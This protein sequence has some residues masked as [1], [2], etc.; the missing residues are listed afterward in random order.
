MK[1]THRLESLRYACGLAVMMGLPLAAGAAE[2]SSEDVPALEPPKGLILAGF[3]ER[4]GIWMV[5]AALL[6][7][8]GIGGLIWWLRRRL[9]PVLP[10]PELTARTELKR[11]VS[12]PE[13]A[14]M[15]ARVG[16]ILRQ[17]LV[18]AFGLPAEAMTTT[19]FCRMIAAEPRIGAEEAGMV[20]VLLRQCDERKFSPGRA[21]Q[22]LDAAR[23]AL[24]LVVL[25]QGRL[26][27]KAAA[28][29]GA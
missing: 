23:R 21:G 11:M 22:P 25:C 6:L 1:P 28:G 29:G 9:P 17:Y 19:E 20:A 8:M 27:V 2:A 5:A 10:A 18:V 12:Q 15:L 7:L 4:Y 3:W 16:I 13:D 26:V 24:E 14:E